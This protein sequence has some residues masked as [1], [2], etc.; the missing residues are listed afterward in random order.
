ML[1]REEEQWFLPC[2]PVIVIGQIFAL[3]LRTLWL[4]KTSNTPC[5]FL[6]KCNINTSIISDAATSYIIFKAPRTGQRPPLPECTSKGTLVYFRTAVYIISSSYTAAAVQSKISFF[7]I[8]GL[9]LSNNSAAIEHPAKFA[10][11][12]WESPKHLIPATAE[13]R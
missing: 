11:K 3:N 9:Y 6:L 10:K 2:P 7:L 4:R 8:F 13:V 1:V 12:T 5:A